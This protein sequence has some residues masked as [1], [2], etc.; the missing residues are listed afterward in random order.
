[1]R[2][3]LGPHWFTT[4]VERVLFELRLQLVLAPCSKDEIARQ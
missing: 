3:V 1:M 4:D 2:G